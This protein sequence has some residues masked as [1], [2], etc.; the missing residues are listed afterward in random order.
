MKTPTSARLAGVF[1]F[2]L[3]KT[4]GREPSELIL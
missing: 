4:D 3:K 2:E 1:I